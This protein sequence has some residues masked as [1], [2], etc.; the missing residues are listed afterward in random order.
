MHALVDDY[1]SF[2]SER[3]LLP[4]DQQTLFVPPCSRSF[5]EN[6]KYRL[7]YCP[8]A[9]T[10]RNAQYLGIYKNRSVRFIGQ[11][12]RVISCDVD[13]TSGKVSATDADETLSLD[14]QNRILGAAKDA[15]GHGWDLS[16]GHKFYL[17]D[18]LEETDFSKRSSGGIMGHRYFDL[19]EVLGSDVPKDLAELAKLLRGCNWPERE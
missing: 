17:C 7:Y 9:W 3:K 4:I 10:R 14:E 12:G 5:A 11:I 15:Q 1:E 19:A 2:C 6:V 16:K 13:L 8:A 18:A